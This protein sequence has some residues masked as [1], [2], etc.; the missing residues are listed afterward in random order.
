MSPGY[1]YEL[2]EVQNRKDERAMERAA[3]I[4]FH[5]MSAW[6]GENTP[7]LDT[8]LGRKRDA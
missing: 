4:C 1:L 6:L 2:G 7:D 3:F 5:I 8:L